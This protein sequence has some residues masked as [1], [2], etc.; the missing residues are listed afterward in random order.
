[1]M[2]IELVS[3]YDTVICV[4]CVRSA[5]SEAEEDCPERDKTL[6][7]QTLSRRQQQTSQMGGNKSQHRKTFF[8]SEQAGIRLRCSSFLKIFQF[9]KYFMCFDLVKPVKY[10]TLWNINHSLIQV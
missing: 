1:M 9:R 3:D 5:C 2:N 4:L 8:L 6:V 10:M 7:N